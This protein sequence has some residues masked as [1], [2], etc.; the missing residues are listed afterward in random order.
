MVAIPFP[1]STS[2]GHRAQEAAGRI[3]NGYA[4]PIQGVPQR[5]AIWRRMA[6]LKTFGT[7]TQSGFRGMTSIPGTL[8]AVFENRVVRF[9]SSGGAATI[10]GNLSGE[11]KCFLARDN[12]ST[13]NVVVVDVDNGAS[14]ITSSSVENYPAPSLPQPNSVCWL[15]GYFFFTIGKQTGGLRGTSTVS[16]PAY[17]KEKAGPGDSKS[18]RSARC[19][20]SSCRIPLQ[21]QDASLHGRWGNPFSTLS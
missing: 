11:K 14:I 4:E 1:L 2:P 3:V 9:T 10:H 20:R 16:E 13:P 17:L 15:G 8:Y 21:D 18:R 12:N 6:G 19:V 5:Q 7:S